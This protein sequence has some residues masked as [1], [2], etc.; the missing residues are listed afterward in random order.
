MVAPLL[1]GAMVGAPGALKVASSIFSRGAKRKAR[2]LEK[3]QHAA[4]LR[5]MEQERDTLMEDA[6]DQEAEAR[7]AYYARGMGDST[8]AQHGM[9]RLKAAHQRAINNMENQLSLARKQKRLGKTTT[10]LGKVQDF[11]DILSGG[12][13]AAGGIVDVTR[14]GK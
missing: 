4:T 14:G 1:M 10:R 6:G 8:Q 7:Q 13:E 3:A 9:T 11:F 5:R 12:A 2:K